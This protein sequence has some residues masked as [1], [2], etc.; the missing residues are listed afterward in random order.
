MN[1]YEQLGVVAANQLAGDG[2]G[3]NSWRVKPKP[4]RGMWTLTKAFSFE[5]AH[6]L[7][8]HDGKCRRLHGHSWRG[9][10]I[11]QGETLNQKGAKSGMLQDFGDI[12]AVLDPLVAGWLDHQHLNETLPM[13]S[14]TSEE[15]ARW[16]FDQLKPSLPLLVA[17]EIDETC[18]SSCRYQP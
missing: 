6:S 13:R 4:N 3:C 9:R 10:V 14:P 2:Q 7:P 5:A 1:P 15:V 17:V 11:L 16:I 12:K 8:D 18:T